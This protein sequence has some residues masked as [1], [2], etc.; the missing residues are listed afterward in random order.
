[1]A[2]IRVFHDNHFVCRAVCQELAG[3]TVGLREI[4]NARS[5]R[6]RN[7]NR[8]IKDRIRAVDMLLKAHRE[9][10]DNPL[11]SELVEISSRN[12]V[13][14]NNLKLYEND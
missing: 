14:E 2:E 10:A 4:V 3:I 12:P 7:L 6:R 13:V 8:K 11:P 1:L 9:P 5:Q